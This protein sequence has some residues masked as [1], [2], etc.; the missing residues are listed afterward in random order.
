[1]FGRISQWNCLS[2]VFP[3]WKVLNYKFNCFNRYAIWVIFSWVSFSS[4]YFSR[5]LSFHLSCRINWP[6]VV[7][8][9]LINILISVVPVL[10]LAPSSL[11]LVIC[12]FYGF[13]FFFGWSVWLEAYQFYWSQRSSFCFHWFFSIFLFSFLISTLIFIFSHFYFH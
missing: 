9:I 11:I 8:N 10:M 6:K 12:V 4:L 2:V 7:H 1:M 5:N 3:L 13:F